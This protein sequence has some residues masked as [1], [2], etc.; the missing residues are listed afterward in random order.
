MTLTTEEMNSN[1]MFVFMKYHLDNGGTVS[2]YNTFS[3]N[4]SFTIPNGDYTNDL[5][6]DTW[7]LSSTQPIVADLKSTYSL[8]DLED[9]E[10]IWEDIQWLQKQQPAVTTYD[11]VE[12]T[13]YAVEGNL[14][15]DKNDNKLYVMTDGSW[16]SLT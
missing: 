6:I 4:Y 9:V 11:R 7:E 1:A 5:V 15:Y 12:L 16:V 8:S 2:N 3:T 13:S 14:L 10:H